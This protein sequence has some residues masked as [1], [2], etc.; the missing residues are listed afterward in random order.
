MANAMQF[1]E[2]L[3]NLLGCK[4]PIS[5]SKIGNLTKLALKLEDHAAEVVEIIE[6]FTRECPPAFKL[7]GLYVIDSICRNSK[8]KQ[9]DD[10]FVPLFSEKVRTIYQN[11]ASCPASDKVCLLSYKDLRR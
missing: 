7:P 2:E 1:Y 3:D 9:K 6:R 5:A 11:L 4:L 8:S 10:I